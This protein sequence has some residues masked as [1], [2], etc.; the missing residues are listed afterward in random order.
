M[1]ESSRW[2]RLP[3]ITAAALT[4]AASAQAPLDVRVALVIGNSAYAFSPLANPV[5]DAAAMSATLKQLGFDVL[6][7]RDASNDQMQ[8]AVEAVHA[9]L[10]GKQA[11][12][13]LYYAGHGL[14][15]DF[16]NYMV[17]VDARLNSA[18]DL[19]KQT[20]DVGV[21]IEAFKVAGN[22]FNIVVLDA[23]RDNPFADKSSGKGLAP[24]DAPAGWNSR[25]P[26]R[27]RRIR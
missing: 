10:N 20:M 2:L 19:P 23:C 26:S 14:Q 8:K 15:A 5:N 12:G 9:K 6:E 25:R 13:M 3:L 18:N 4:F 21:V 1:A 22:R 16:H 17:P 27:R 24:M 7:L 11:V